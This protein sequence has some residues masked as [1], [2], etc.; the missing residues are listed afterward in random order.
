MVT[1]LL[2][3]SY[4]ATFLIGRVYGQVESALIFTQRINSIIDALKKVEN[5]ALLKGED[6]SKL[7]T[8]DL[9]ERA[10]KHMETRN[11]D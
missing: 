11:D 10:R 8:K 7:S 1:A 2:V 5:L 4:I 9:I 3:I 6:L